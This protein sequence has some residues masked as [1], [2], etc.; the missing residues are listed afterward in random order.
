MVGPS[1]DEAILLPVQTGADLATLAIGVDTNAFRPVNF[2]KEEE[3]DAV[4][5]EVDK[6]NR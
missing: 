4:A 1:S 6:L 5:V 3:A 2:D